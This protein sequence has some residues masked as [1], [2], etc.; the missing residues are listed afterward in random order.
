M[1]VFVSVCNPL[2]GHSGECQKS[3]WVICW[4]FIQMCM[5][6]EI[7]QSLEIICVVELFLPENTIFFLK[8]LNFLL[9][10]AIYLGD[11]I[12]VD[13]EIGPLGWYV[14]CSQLPVSHAL[15]Q[16][17]SF[18]MWQLAEI[19]GHMKLWLFSDI[20]NQASD[21]SCWVV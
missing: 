20:K 21:H 11:L 16:S 2:S 3:N 14:I 7:F 15:K 5:C 17:V 4:S 19:L 18:Q 13:M 12:A 8:E 1:T 6:Y 9:N 10:S